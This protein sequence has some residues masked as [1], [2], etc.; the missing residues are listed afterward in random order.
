MAAA[1]LL[2]HSQRHQLTQPAE[3]FCFLPSAFCFPNE[4]FALP[5]ATKVI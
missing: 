2:T 1:R 5:N 3:H 4:K